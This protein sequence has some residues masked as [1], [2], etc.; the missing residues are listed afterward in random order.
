MKSFVSALTLMGGL[1]V[2][3]VVSVVWSGNAAM[4]QDAAP[5]KAPAKP[6]VDC[7]TVNDATLTAQV[8]EK[9]ANTPSLKDFT[10][11]VAVKDGA[12]TLTGTVKTGR[13]KGTAT[14]QTKRVAC[15]RKVDNQLTVETAASKA[16]KS[17]Q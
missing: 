10:I 7:S 13:N 12:V 3:L 1:V 6:A 4:A 5:K 11:N 8:K 16:P 14:L 2:C 15:V 9:L 17:G